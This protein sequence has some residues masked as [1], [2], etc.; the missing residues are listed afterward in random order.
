MDGSSVPRATTEREPEPV[1]R[2]G[3]V[4]GRSRLS[5]MGR[6]L[7]EVLVAIAMTLAC[8]CG[9]LALLSVA[10]PPGDDLR[11]LM[12]GVRMTGLRGAGNTSLGAELLDPI[13][14][15]S[16]PVAKLTVR[17]RDVKRRFAGQIAWSPAASGLDLHD[18]D[19]VQTGPGGRASIEFG[20]TV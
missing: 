8:F 1:A 14:S 19:A 2:P 9:F 15:A 18:R 10:F 16:S 11:T 6:L 5:G 3:R 7:L 12:A 13:A 17:R 4:A 20:P